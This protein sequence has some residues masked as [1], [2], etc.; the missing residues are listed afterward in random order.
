MEK[1]WGAER[2]VSEEFQQ[3]DRSLN[4]ESRG[5]SRSPTADVGCEMALE[6]NLKAAKARAHK[7]TTLGRKA[8]HMNQGPM[9][10]CHGAHL[11]RQAHGNTDYGT[12]F[13]SGLAGMAAF[14]GR[15]VAGR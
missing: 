4:T 13:P 11:P 9:P 8:Q 1:G 14:L 5:S 7:Q 10:L 2:S 15:V 12:V 3:R 6:L